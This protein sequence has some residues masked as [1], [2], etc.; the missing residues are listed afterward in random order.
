LHGWISSLLVIY[1][2]KWAFVQRG[3]YSSFSYLK[4][5]AMPTILG[6]ERHNMP[7][8]VYI[9]YVLVCSTGAMEKIIDVEP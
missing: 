6:R 9:H 1:H 7:A 8:L 5:L 3:N 2:A 4:C